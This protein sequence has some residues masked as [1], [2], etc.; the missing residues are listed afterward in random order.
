VQ[1]LCLSSEGVYPEPQHGFRLRPE[2]LPKLIEGLQKLQE[3]K[4]WFDKIVK[5]GKVNILNKDEINKKYPRIIN[6][7]DP[8]LEPPFCNRILKIMLWGE[9]LDILCMGI[10]ITRLPIRESLKELNLPS[11]FNPLFSMHPLVNQIKFDSEVL[12]QFID[13][14]QQVQGTVEID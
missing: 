3:K 5:E 9:L 4:E 13:F 14:L 10:Y 11:L 7:F 6:I 8:N 2:F 1:P 12:P